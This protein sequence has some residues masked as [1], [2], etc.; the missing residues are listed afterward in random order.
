MDSA[1]MRISTGSTQSFLRICSRRASAVIGKETITS[2]RVLRA[3]STRSSIVPSFAGRRSVAAALGAAVVEQPDDADV[4][5]A[6]FQRAD[7]LFALSPP[8]TTTA[9]RSS[10]PSPV[11]RR[12]TPYKNMRKA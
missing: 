10:R 6:G 4:R 5:R 8:P 2:T 12:T 9:R 11:Q 1:E 7:E 3:K